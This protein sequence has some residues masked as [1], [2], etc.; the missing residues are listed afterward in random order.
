[1]SGAR[2]RRLVA[3]IVLQLCAQRQGGGSRSRE[4]ASQGFGGAGVTNDAGGLE[5]YLDDLKAKR[6]ASTSD[7]KRGFYETAVSDTEKRLKETL[8][9][10]KA[11]ATKTL[12]ELMKAPERPSGVEK[13]NPNGPY[14]ALAGVDARTAPGGKRTV[15]PTGDNGGGAGSEKLDAFDREERATER[16]IRNLGAEAAAVGKSAYEAA[17]AE[18]QFKLM[19][20]A[21]QAGPDDHAATHGQDQRTVRGLCDR[22]D[23]A[24][25]GAAG[26]KS[27]V[28]LQGFIGDGFI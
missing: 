24:R 14:G 22:R 18:A 23:E 21:K 12:G 15:L 7:F 27:E 1:M 9:N 17:N 28:Q 6:D 10:A 8:A 4:L 5:K 25:R 26:A 2:L 3:E 20:A 19:D 11:D 16:R 13:Y